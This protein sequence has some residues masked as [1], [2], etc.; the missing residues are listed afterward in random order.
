MPLS[1]RRQLDEYLTFAESLAREAGQLT[2]RYFRGRAADLAIE[3]KA[4]QTPV[5]IADRETEQLIRARIAE[6]YPD[7]GILGEE[8]DELNPGA[9]WRWVVDPIDGTKAFI[10]GIPL[11]SVLLALEFEGV[12]RLGVIHNPALDE[13]V[14]AAAGLGCSFNGQPCHVS[15]T[16]ELA[17]A[18]LQTTDYADLAKSRPR[19]CAELLGRVGHAR[20]W[21]D[22]YGYL[23]V[24]TGRADIMIDPIMSPWDVAPMRPII[25]EAGG[26]ITDLD[27]NDSNDMRHTLV[28]NPVLHA[29]VLELVKLDRC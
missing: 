13:T 7:H 14:A 17:A 1:L 22:A 12:A 3:Q 18:W 28:A 24:A 19:L 6:C 27:G 10:H 9:A 25:E 29:Q 2:L 5:T 11:Y 8:Y 16:T 15:A 4:D 21:G 23:L 26:L 20:T